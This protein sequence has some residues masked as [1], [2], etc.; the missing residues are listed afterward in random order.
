MELYKDLETVTKWFKALEPIG[1]DKKGGVT[2]LGYSKTEDVMH[3]AIRNIARNLG[4]KS[5]GD[6]VGNTYIHEK[7]YDKYYVIGSHLDSVINGGRYDGVAGILSGLLVLKWIKE[8]G[9]NIPVKVAAFRCEES[10]AFGIATVG[11]SLITHTLDVDIM[12]QV[13]N[14]EGNSL[15]E[16]LKSKGYNPHCKKIEG[17]LGYFELHI[18]QGRVLEVS[19]KKI[20]IVNAIAAATRYW[21]FIEGRQDHSGAT[22]MGIRKDALCA[23]AEIVTELEKY[24]DEEAVNSTV[25]T[26]GYIAN[27]PN[28][29]NVIPGNVKMGIDIRGIDKKSIN[30]VDDEIVEFIKKVCEKRGLKYKLVPISKAKPVKLDEELKLNLAKTAEELKEEY[31]IMNSGAGH[32]AMKFAEITPTGM[33]FI[34]CR[35]GVSHNKDEDINFEDVV[36]GSKIIFEQLKKLALQ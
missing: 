12:K 9:L 17:V 35:D 11:S 10:S 24:A 19:N 15:Y 1:T 13:K 23:A 32:D 33:V 25:G 27:S 28:A 7:N 2:R 14:Q 34:P 8:E 36:R 5:S 31:M 29:F 26:I 22:P 20:G 16:T 21:L 18:E 3:G 30:K 4:L 6:E